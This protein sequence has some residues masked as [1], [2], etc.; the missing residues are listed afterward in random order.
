MQNILFPT[1]FTELSINAFNYALDYAK[2]TNNTLIVFHAY[3]PNVEVLEETE[4]VY[5]KIDIQNFR[6]KKDAFPPFEKIIEEKGYND[7]AIKYVV[8]EGNFIDTFKKYVW[9][10]EDKIDLVIMGAHNNRNRLLQMFIETN[11][12]KILEEIDKPVIAVPEGSIFD[13]NIDTILFLVDYQEDEKEPLVNLIE[14]AREFDAK[15]DVVHFDLAH[16]ESIVPQ[17]ESFKNSLKLSNYNN[18]E[19]T[20]IDTIDI[21]ES[22]IKYCDE[23]KIDIVCLINHQRNFYQRLFSYSLAEELINNINIPIMAIYRG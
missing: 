23:N 5:K 7:I 3:D 19:F 2:K 15:I 9:K 1:D 18:I 21:K 14:K 20:S 22:L 6:N 17:M 4:K 13:G 12:I 10:R 8:K 16:S 11:T